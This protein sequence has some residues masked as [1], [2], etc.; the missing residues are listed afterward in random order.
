[1]AS[2]MGGMT[3]P[4]PAPWQQSQ[5][6]G[7]ADPYLLALQGI[8]STVDKIYTLMVVAV[9]LGVVGGLLAI[10]RGISG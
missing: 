4:Q 1:M 6:P 2:R 3:T 8:R 10:F 9:I 5:A 7:Q